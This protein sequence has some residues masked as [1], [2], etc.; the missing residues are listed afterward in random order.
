MRK[1]KVKEIFKTLQGEGY[2]AGRPAIFIRF[3]GCNLWTGREEDRQSAICKFCDTD[4]LGGQ[5][6]DAHEICRKASEL[7]GTGRENRFCVLTGGEPALQV[8]FQL[9]ATLRRYDFHVAIETNG[10][11]NIDLLADWITVSP[12]AGAM[13]LIQNWGDEL[14]LVYPQESL[15]P[16]QFTEGFEHYFLQPMDGADKDRNTKLAIE[17]CQANPRWRLSI[18]VHKIVGIA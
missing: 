11:K 7:W 13:P 14:K 12:K 5:K 18:Q 16:A 10:T 2:W 9:I 6:M 4:F 3:A 15:D 17:Y 1:F 8:D